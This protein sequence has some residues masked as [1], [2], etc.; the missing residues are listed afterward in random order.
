M[1]IDVQASVHT[2]VSRIQDIIAKFV[3]LQ[4]TQVSAWNQGDLLSCLLHGAMLQ[5]SE[6]C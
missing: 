1:E 5:H 2:Q 4:I 6:K 3:T